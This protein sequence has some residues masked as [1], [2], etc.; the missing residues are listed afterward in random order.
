MPGGNTEDSDGSLLDTAEREAAEEMGGLPAG[1]SVMHRLDT[2]R[3]AKG[4]GGDDDDGFKFYAVFVCRVPAAGAAA[5]KPKLEEDEV[6]DWRWWS[7]A[8]AKAAAGQGKMHPVM[9]EALVG[10]GANELGQ[11]LEGAKAG[12]ARGD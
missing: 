9:T 11:V 3:D 8:D 1:F 2:R 7:I 4:G 6:R 12:E 10:T 5:F